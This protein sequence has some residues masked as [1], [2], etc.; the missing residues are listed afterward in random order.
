MPHKHITLYATKAAAM[1][2]YGPLG[3]VERPLALRCVMLSLQII[4]YYGLIRVC[5]ILPRPYLLRLSG[6]CPTASYGLDGTDSPICSVYLLLRAIFRTPGPWQVHRVVS[7]CCFFL[8]SISL[9]HLCTGSATASPRT[10]VL[11]W[12]RNEAAKFA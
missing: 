11:A 7:S 12:P 8:D 1:D 5:P 10:P 9:R 4:A 3:H 2:S 6:L